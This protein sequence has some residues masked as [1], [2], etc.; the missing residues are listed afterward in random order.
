MNEGI[1]RNVRA[2][3]ESMRKKGDKDGANTRLRPI[4]TIG[5]LGDPPTAVRY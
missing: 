3:V 2:M 1:V 5:T 4:V